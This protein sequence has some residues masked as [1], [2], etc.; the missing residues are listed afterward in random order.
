MLCFSYLK[1]PMSHSKTQFMYTWGLTMWLFFHT[2]KTSV[3]TIFKNTLNLAV[4]TS[5]CVS[6]QSF[7]PLMEHC[8]IYCCNTTTS[9][10]SVEQGETSGRNAHCT[11]IRHKPNRDPLMKT[12]LFITLLVL[13]LSRV[14]LEV[15]G[16]NPEMR[17]PCNGVAA[18]YTKKKR[19]DKIKAGWII[20]IL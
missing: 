18:R 7:L 19:Y 17:L 3:N 20:P 13:T 2:H 8:Y 16:S 6:L 15:L 12:L 14:P 9:C 1:G 10:Q 4:F 5:I 11:C